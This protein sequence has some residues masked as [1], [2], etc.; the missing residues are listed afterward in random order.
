MSRRRTKRGS[1]DAVG[2]V[3]RSET[4]RA[5]IV[6]AAIEE[7]AAH[8]FHAAKVSDIVSRAGVTQP[9]FYFYFPSKQAIYDHLIQRAHDELLST[10]RA[11][12]LPPGVDRANVPDMVRAAIEAFL[13]YF[14]D[15]RLLANIGYFQSPISAA[16]RDEIISV[17]SRHIAYEQGAGYYRRD[18]DPV[19]IAEC[20]GGTLER[21]IQR[22]LFT[23]RASV[24]DLAINVAE[25]FLNGI[26]YVDGDCASVENN[27]RKG[28]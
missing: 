4:T 16:I 11:A 21:V 28:S 5:Q 1:A 3:K 20:Y 10:I 12:R 2:A 13:Q 18:R 27:S 9:A 19:F 24:R 7:F 25:I 15:N 26:L 14:V 6:S 22:Y 8:G 17:L 23:G